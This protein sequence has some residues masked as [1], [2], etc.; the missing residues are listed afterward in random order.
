M[1]VCHETGIKMAVHM[2]DPPWDIFGL[3]RLLIDRES[4]D[5]F[6]KMVASSLGVSIEKKDTEIDDWNIAEFYAK[7]NP[8]GFDKRL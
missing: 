8:D 4:I 6:L 5:R 7:T 1:P 2:D 3:P